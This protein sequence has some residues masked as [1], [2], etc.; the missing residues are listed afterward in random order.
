MNAPPPIVSRSP[1]AEWLFARGIR[2]SAAA[3]DLGCSKQTI[4]NV[5]KPFS[6]AGRTVPH[7]ALMGRIV[8]YTG[9]EITASDFYP[10][11]LR[12]AAEVGP[13]ADVAAR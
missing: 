4:L 13:T 11:H 9:R 1:F 5:C 8:A 7:E 2:P 12:S 6:D 10:E 3:V